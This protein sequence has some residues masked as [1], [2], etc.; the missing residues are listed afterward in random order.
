MRNRRTLSLVVML[1]IAFGSLAATLVV[2]NKPQLGLD[3]QGGAS[4]VLQPPAGT[5]KGTVNQA[6]E[7]IRSRVDALGVAE[8]QISRQG[9]AIVV[10][11]PG[12]KNQ[13]KALEVVGTTAE[14][15]FRPVLGELP[16]EGATPSTTSTTSTTVPGKTATQNAAPTTSTTSTT[17]P[18]NTTRANNKAD[19]VVILPDKDPNVGRYQLGPAGAVGK[20]I[21]T[22][23]ATVS[24]A[25]QWSVDLSMTSDGIKAF[26]QVAGE[27]YNKAASCPTGQLAIELDGI[28]QSA[29]AIQAPTFQ[30]DQINISGSF[31]QSEAKDLALVLR[32]GSLPVQLEQQT[33][34]TV[35][36]TLGKDSLHAGLI[37]GIIGTV[38]VL[39]Y[40][41]L[42]YRILGLVVIAGL[43]IWFSLQWSIISYL[44]VSNGLALSLSGVTGIVVSVGVTVDS[45]VVYFERLKD[46]LHAGR[47]M[48]SAIDTAFK[49]S[50]RTVVIAD[51]AAF[52]A[53]AVLY[54][55]TVGPVRG[56]AFFLGL[57]TV[58]DVVVAYFFKRPLVGLLGR[59][60]LLQRS[61]FVGLRAPV[62][63]TVRPGLGGASR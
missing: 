58:L 21:S 20:A 43:A 44:G 50:F 34:R 33:V 30:K 37:A 52:L 32:Y 51:T 35:S 47:T 38:L 59:W 9:N 11:L 6:I 61:K 17:L 54:F 27:C 4:V 29:P 48:R 49:H 39:L 16:P 23:G 8:P 42:Y 13:E 5:P 55:L 15:R 10:E 53:A 1:I 25:G 36:A 60:G 46:E 12:V 14:L 7:I 19:A 41:I 40:M 28:V 63:E 57:A 31:S 2:G 45:Y 22:A 56:F 18:P 24:Q 26:N 3:L 62:P